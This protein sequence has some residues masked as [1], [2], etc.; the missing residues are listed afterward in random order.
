MEGPC[1]VPSNET[2]KLKVCCRQESLMRRLQSSNSS[3]VASIWVFGS[4]RG[5]RLWVLRPQITVPVL[6][7]CCQVGLSWGR[8]AGDSDRPDS[9]PWNRTWE[10][11]TFRSV[12]LTLSGLSDG[13]GLSEYS[14]RDPRNRTACNSMM[15]RMLFP[16][17]AQRAFQGHTRAW[18]SA[19]GVRVPPR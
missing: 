10:F 8:S 15:M 2:R 4:V 12:S 11:R 9:Q 14:A 18:S 6:S 5:S 17:L 7:Q 16:T 1:F 19:G 13:I 3:S